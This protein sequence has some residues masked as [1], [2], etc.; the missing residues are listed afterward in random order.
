MIGA[1]ELPAALERLV[2]AEALSAYPCECCGL[3]EGLADGNVVHVVA[4]HPMPNLAQEPDRFEIDPAAHIA[5]L[6]TFRSTGREIIGC[7]HSHPNGRADP[8]ERDLARASERDF[9]W[10][11]CAVETTTEATS[12][13]AFVS[14]GHSFAPVPIMTAPGTAG[15]PRA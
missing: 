5:L 3:I 7:Y 13:A 6:R 15:V 9:L 8:S 10:L 2:R 14:T 4:L 11:I 12:I 1:V